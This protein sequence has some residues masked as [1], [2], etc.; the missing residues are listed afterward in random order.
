M[1][2]PSSM[3]CQSAC[4]CRNSPTRYLLRPPPCMQLNVLG[5]GDTLDIP[6]WDDSC[7]RQGGDN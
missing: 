7:K 2:P 1:V 5:V 3:S 4:V 6:P